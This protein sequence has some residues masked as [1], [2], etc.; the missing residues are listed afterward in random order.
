MKLRYVLII[1]LIIVIVSYYFVN[2]FLLQNQAINKQSFY[3]RLQSDWNSYPGNIVYDVT[4][5]WDRNPDAIQLDP[6]TRLELSKQ[7]NVDQVRQVHGKSYI[8][9]HHG[10]TKCYDMWE[11]HYAR[12]GADTIRHYVEYVMGIQKSP[13]PNINLY[14]LAEGKQDKATHEAQI[15]SGFSQFIPVCTQKDV[16]S[17]DYSIKL[18]DESVGFDVYFVPSIK[19]QEN[20]DQNKN[21]FTHYSDGQCFGKN[22]NRFSGTC[23]NVA[24]DSGLLIILPDSLTLPLTKVEIWLYEK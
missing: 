7:A 8:T 22:Y 10:N 18:N 11:P 12:F 21:S 5:V 4:N 15:R 6:K 16:T 2:A 13:D 1:V 17:F 3:V 20:Y 14:T 19:E 9:V 24:K 23:K